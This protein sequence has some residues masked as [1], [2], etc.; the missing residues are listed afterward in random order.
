MAKQTIALTSEP[1]GQLGT[2]F[3]ARTRDRGLLPA[4]IYGRK[5]DPVAVAFDQHA[6]TEALHHGHRLF[7]T[8]LGSEKQTLLL[9][10]VQ[11]D[12]LGRCII[13]ADLV[14]VS[15][16][17]TVRVSVPIEQRGTSKGSHEGG[18]I[19]EVMAQIEI[20]CLV[21]EIPD[22]LVV[23]VKELT[24]GDSVRARDVILPPGAKL[25]T[26]PNA[27]VLHCHIVAAAKTSEE[28]EL[29]TPVAPEVITERVAEPE[30]GGEQPEKAAKEKKPAEKK[31]AEKKAAKEEG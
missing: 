7:E 25:V 21:T 18:I 9:K 2:R 17:D 10:D 1:R 27:V 3:A 15:L 4:I 28:L 19:D 5:Q 8:E 11:Y 16:T 23:S 22:S 13:H 20:E 14:R 29:E 24:V 12:H 31:P 26:D 30:E 6:F